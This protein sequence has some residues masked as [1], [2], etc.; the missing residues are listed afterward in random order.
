[1]T[2]VLQLLRFFLPIFLINLKNKSLMK[3]TLH[4]N[5]GWWKNDILTGDREKVRVRRAYRRVLWFWI[6]VPWWWFKLFPV[7]LQATGEPQMESDT[8]RY[9]VELADNRYKFEYS[10]SQY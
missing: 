10:K 6:R 7:K 9:Q 3:F 5:A 1:M 4:L 2:C 8:W